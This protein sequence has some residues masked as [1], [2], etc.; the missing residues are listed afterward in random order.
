MT[1][2]FEEKSGIKTIRTLG[3]IRDAS[4]LKIHASLI[5]HNECIK[6]DPFQTGPYYPR[7]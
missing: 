5:D 6:N 1:I 4:S 2:Y 7:G 3:K